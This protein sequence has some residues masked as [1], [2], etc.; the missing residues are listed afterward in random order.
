MNTPCSP[1]NFW[2]HL[3]KGDGLTKDGKQGTTFAASNE[4]RDKCRAPFAEGN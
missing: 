1:W 3:T 2:H 4:K